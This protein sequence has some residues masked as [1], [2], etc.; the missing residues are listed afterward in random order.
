M[1][2]LLRQC[3]EAVRTKL[4]PLFKV[5]ASS[6]SAYRRGWEW[7][8]G[9]IWGGAA[10]GAQRRMLVCRAAQVARVVVVPSLPRNA[11]NK[12]SRMWSGLAAQRERR[13]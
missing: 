12:V 6:C 5:R 13:C 8:D 11:S 3:Q 9:T 4:N 10:R 7:E 2:E 1:K